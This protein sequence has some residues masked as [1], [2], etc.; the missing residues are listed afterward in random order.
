[1]SGVCSHCPGISLEKVGAC[2][3]MTYDSQL[4]E[5]QTLDESM[6]SFWELESFGVPTTDQPL[7]DEFSDT[8]E[9]QEGRYKVQLS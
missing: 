8:F 7:Y 6:K 5:D 4:F 2:A 9:F 3:Y 1:M